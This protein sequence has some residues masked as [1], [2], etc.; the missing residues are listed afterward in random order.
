MSYVAYQYAEA[1]FSIS[2]EQSVLNDINNEFHNFSIAL[3]K[4]IIDFLVHPKISKN[5]KKNIV[6]KSLDNKVFRNF[7]NVLIDNSRID[8]L[9]EIKKEFQNIIN[10]QNNLLKVI[11]YSNKLL[12]DDQ[13]R[14]LSKSLEKK[15]N[16]KIELENI[17][18]ESIVGGMRI[19]YE[20]K[21]FDDTINNYLS[22]L[23]ANLTK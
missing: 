10:K 22:S 15:N 3:D 23:K 5:E 12:T 17:V 21:V 9:D 14:D 8:L 13:L 2:K 6:A 20:D 1:L 11:A 18:D 16:R 4:E 7:I 19:E